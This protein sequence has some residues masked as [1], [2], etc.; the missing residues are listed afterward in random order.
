MRR[1][2]IIPEQVEAA[3]ALIVSA[4]NPEIQVLLRSDDKD[5]LTERLVRLHVAGAKGSDA[6]ELDTAVTRVI[7]DRRASPWELGARLLITVVVVLTVIAAGLLAASFAGQAFP[8]LVPVSWLTW[9][10][11]SRVFRG[12]I[13]LVVV[14][15]AL[16]YGA[17]WLRSIDRVRRARLACRLAAVHE[18][19]SWPGILLEAPFLTLGRRWSYPGWSFIAAG[20]VLVAGSVSI[21][22]LSAWLW[23]VA[24]VWIALGGWL[25]WRSWPFRRAQD[26]A[27]R[28]LFLGR[29]D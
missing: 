16:G 27:E 10:P 11:S 23:I 22:G 2:D 9:P 26:L 24:I 12:V 14:A 3:C 29:S 1:G 15:V 19:D 13:L 28:T 21:S 6:D 8:R 7:V 17:V 20:L 18:L 4:L 25:V 5:T